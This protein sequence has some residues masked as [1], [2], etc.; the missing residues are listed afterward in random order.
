[1]KTPVPTSTPAAT[2]WHSHTKCLSRFK[3]GC[4]LRCARCR[5]VCAVLHH[6]GRTTMVAANM[7]HPT[8]LGDGGACSRAPPSSAHKRQYWLHMPAGTLLRPTQAPAQQ[9]GSWLLLGPAAVAAAAAAAPP[10]AAQAAAAPARRPCATQRS[11]TWLMC[12]APTPKLWNWAASPGRAT[13]A[14]PT[15]ASLA[16][17]CYTPPASE[18][19]QHTCG[20][21]AGFVRVV[22]LSKPD[23]PHDCNNLV[24]GRKQWQRCWDWA[25]PDPRCL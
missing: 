24:P 15:T 18:S 2:T 20:H 21:Q 14:S 23:K 7:K 13:W 11:V 8:V 16:A 6:D 1:M 17:C 25:P 4:T 12:L 22:N 10:A 3:S 9:G 5:S 19:A